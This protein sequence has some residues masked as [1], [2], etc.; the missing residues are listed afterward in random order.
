MP[1]TSAWLR[2]KSLFSKPIAT[3]PEESSSQVVS[4]E[5]V[6]R[7]QQL[8]LDHTFVDVRFPERAGNSYQSLILNVNPDEGYLLIDEFFPSSD[9]ILV[10]PGDEVEITS[11]RK[12][13]PVS[14]STVVQSICIDDGDGMPA[15]RLEIPD[16]VEARQRRRHFRVQVE[17][18]A[19]IKVRIP[20]DDNTTLLCTVHNLSYS[21]IGFSTGGNIAQQLETQ[22][23][24]SNALL[25]L[26]SEVTIQCKIEVMSYEF[27]RMPY[28]HTLIGGKF[29]AISSSNQKKLDQYLATMQRIQRKHTSEERLMR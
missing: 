20:N 1:Q 22:R 18:D 21:G 27:K 17:P 13:M 24:F 10:S 19:G 7:L 12:G 29:S 15:Y 11:Q 9:N 25:T 23:I 3:E 28:R 2:L 4:A 16:S 5:T 8:A 26:P 14:F 6:L